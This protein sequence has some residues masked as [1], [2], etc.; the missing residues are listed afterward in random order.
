M[1]SYPLI[2]IH[3]SAEGYPLLIDNRVAEIGGEIGRGSERGR[4]REGCV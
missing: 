2:D 3:K 4:Q 1:I